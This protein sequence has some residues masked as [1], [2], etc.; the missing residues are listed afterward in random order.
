MLPMYL[1]LAHFSQ[2]NINRKRYNP[3]F[4]SMDVLMSPK[5]RSTVKGPFGETFVEPGEEGVTVMRGSS[6]ITSI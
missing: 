5:H 2:S 6:S 4:S 1:A 3:S